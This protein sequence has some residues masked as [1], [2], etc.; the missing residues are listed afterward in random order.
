MAFSQDNVLGIKQDY[1]GRPYTDKVRYAEFGPYA[2]NWKSEVEKGTADPQG[3]G[4]DP[5]KT[6][7]VDVSLPGDPLFFD[8]EGRGGVVEARDV[9]SR[10]N[11]KEA[12]AAKEKDEME[13]RFQR[14]LKVLPDLQVQMRQKQESQRSGTAYDPRAGD[15]TPAATAIERAQ[16]GR[17]ALRELE[18]AE[19][20][21]R[22][23]DK[24]YVS[25]TPA[26][27]AIQGK[28]QSSLNLF[29]NEASASISAR[30][31]DATTTHYAEQINQR[32]SEF[33]QIKTKEQYEEFLKSLTGPASSAAQVMGDAGAVIRQSQ[34]PRGARQQDRATHAQVG[35]VSV[36]NVNALRAAGEQAMAQ[37]NPSLYAEIA[38][39]SAV[40]RV[41]DTS[42]G[43]W[44]RVR[45]DGAT[46]K[47]NAE[48]T[49]M[50]NSDPKLKA[51]FAHEVG[52]L[53]GTGNAALPMDVDLRDL[54]GLQLT[55]EQAKARV[56]DSKGAVITMGDLVAREQTRIMAAGGMSP[57]RR[58]M[59]RANAIMEVQNAQSQL[60]RRENE[61]EAVA[62]YGA[63]SQV[64]GMMLSDDPQERERARQAIQMRGGD[65]AVALSYASAI[66]EI[67]TEVTAK[68]IYAEAL[69]KSSQSG[70][71]G[72]VLI[73]KP[74]YESAALA[75][76]VADN[77][78]STM[79]LSQMTDARTPAWQLDGAIASV[80]KEAGDNVVPGNMK[81]AQELVAETARLAT[82]I[83][84][85]RWAQFKTTADDTIYSEKIKPM[86]VSFVS[87]VPMV[88]TWSDT[89]T[90]RELTN[91]SNAIG[92]N[93]TLGMS[94]DLDNSK[95]VDTPEEF[96]AAWMVQQYGAEMAPFAKELALGRFSLDGKPE[97]SREMQTAFS[98]VVDR[99]E[100]GMAAAGAERRA[101]EAEI[102]KAHPLLAS[103]FFARS[104]PEEEAMHEMMYKGGVYSADLRVP[105]NNVGAVIVT[106]GDKKYPTRNPEYAKSL[107][108]MLGATQNAEVRQALLSAVGISAD[109][110]IGGDLSPKKLQILSAGGTL[111]DGML[112]DRSNESDVVFNGVADRAII[113]AFKSKTEGK[114]A[115][116]AEFYDTN[117]PGYEDVKAALGSKPALN[118]L[119]SQGITTGDPAL[120]KKAIRLARET[121]RDETQ[122]HV[123]SIINVTMTQQVNQLANLLE[124]DTSD[125]PMDNPDAA[126]SALFTRVIN[127]YREQEPS[128]EPGRAK[129]AKDVALQI[130]SSVKDLKNR[131]SR[132]NGV[133]E[134]LDAAGKARVEVAQELVRDMK[135]FVPGPIY[136]GFSWTDV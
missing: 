126:R 105:A 1:L 60:Q 131:E 24:S 25:V 52:S 110:L 97:V 32:S 121:V 75:K 84:N 20:R 135:S 80:L 36:G 10:D 41:N 27:P 46:D 2:K 106:V 115:P 128:L 42:A 81:A 69:K 12:L 133:G 103:P 99:I 101:A 114:Q 123:G 62:N 16:M 37:L 14:A 29:E 93:P 118:A 53:A 13:A 64:E 125:I 63:I 119:W 91:I 71:E 111:H 89:Q 78:V 44:Y 67:D 51:Q 59:E 17:M 108:S 48:L 74:G 26:K 56:T 7:P 45:I 90:N 11:A 15:K 88:A 76:R 31:L 4:W 82:E 5:Y 113:K 28:Q 8:V 94:L 85:E 109:G 39:S 83:L 58:A 132:L 68:N 96:A 66:T 107:N 3:F 134:A 124:I 54:M 79:D 72:D 95:Q 50:I 127:A 57:E 116:G 19:A 61:F 34:L 117:I 86:A 21:Q 22:E 70:E 120:C 112:I 65:E 38:H 18:K 73:V 100:R 43:T 33:A 102:I 87:D 77:F 129:L 9:L 35:E 40:K 30:D 98:I 49:E 23:I 55:D 130:Y 122:E 136:R 47:T 6:E 92:A 104:T